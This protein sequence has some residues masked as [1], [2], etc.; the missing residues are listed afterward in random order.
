MHTLIEADEIVV[1]AGLTGLVY[2]N[3]MA[4]SGK[5]VVVVEKHTKPG[6]YASNFVR[7][8]DYTFDCSLHKITGFGVNGNL[9][10]ALERAGLI[11]LLPFYPYQEL[12]TIIHGSSR[13]TLPADGAQLEQFLLSRFPSAQEG[14]NAFFH[15]IKTVGYQNYMLARMTLGE[16]EMDPELFL[17]S[18]KLNRMT[19]YEYLLSTFNDRDLITILCALAIN[20]GVEAFEADAL[21]FL[22]FAY[23]FMYTEKRY[24][25]GSSQS[26][27]NALAQ[28]LERRGG[29]LLLR[30]EVTA[31][32]I[33][34][35]SIKGCSTRRYKIKAP[36]MVWTGSPSQVSELAGD[37]VPASFSNAFSALE[38]GLGTF[39]VYLGLSETPEHCGFHKSDYL[40][41]D[42]S[43]LDDAHHAC[44]SD[45]RYERWPLSISNYHLLDN[46]YG[47]VIQLEILDQMSDWF[48]L[49]RKDYKKKKECVAERILDR[50]ERS[51]PGLR[52]YIQYMDISTPKTN[53]KFTNSL[54]G[55]AFG[56]KPVPR[57]NSRFLQHPPLSG[58]QFL[59]TW[60]NGA[61]YEPAMCLG[62][63]AA[64]LRSQQKTERTPSYA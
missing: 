8:R 47:F 38:P 42:T 39:I 58:L 56:Y 11:D 17:S 13:M 10:N 48:H 14:L 24:V 7:K 64:T 60:V 32:D 6:G 20:L 52:R 15:D 3:V 54:G 37:Q 50:A 1:G 46:Q 23:T 63:T 9:S 40:I 28:E 27:S 35:S 29:R 16:Y 18:R 53:Y 41:T 19:T 49:S 36:H 51:F 22:H 33:S 31:I 30:E 59:G 57:R 44:H 62:F 61:G 12:T 45:L 4:A 25:K 55:S 2:A 34:H 21:Y 43:Y 5:R 26:W